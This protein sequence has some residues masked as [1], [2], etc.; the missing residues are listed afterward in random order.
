MKKVFKIVLIPVVLLLVLG[1][2]VFAYIKSMMP[3][4]DGNSDITEGYYKNFR[5]DAPLEMKYSG[6]GSYETAYTEFSSDNASIGKVRVWYPKELES[7]GKAWPMIMVVNASGTPASSYEPF[8]PRLASWGFIVVGNEDG[9][10]GNG[11]TASITLDFML[12]LPASSVLSGK[13]DYDSMGLIGYSQG[14]AGALCALTNYENGKRYRAI[15]TGSAAYPTLAK[16][17][18]WEYDASKVT[19]PYFMCAG[20][21]R[22]DDSGAD[23]EKSYG[24]VS[25]LSA[26]ITSYDS[27]A[28]DVPKIRARAVGAEHEQ[29]LARSD[30][31]MTAWMLCQLTEDE[32]AGAVFFGENAEIL[33]NANWQDVE[34]NR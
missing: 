24:G 28:D 25:P 27:I 29:M 19:V 11:E 4:G 21:G 12:N 14:G 3:G 10:T 18:G 17:M 6:L 20:T 7:G 30:G 1:I 26:L 32:E 13:I 23:P 2:A 5:S 31:Y 16:N 22:S 33:G 34:K 15:F 9:Q 8:F